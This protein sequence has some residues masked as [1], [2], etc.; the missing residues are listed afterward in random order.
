MIISLLLLLRHASTGCRRRTALIGGNRL[1]WSGHKSRA[2]GENVTLIQVL[3]F[4]CFYR[5]PT[6]ES[7]AQD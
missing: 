5:V 1:K 6:A 3:R 4:N 7:K 2:L